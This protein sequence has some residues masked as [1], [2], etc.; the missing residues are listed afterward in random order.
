MQ[1]LP[2]CRRDQLSLAQQ[3]SPESKHKI[4]GQPFPNINCFEY[5]S[6]I[7]ASNG[8]SQRRRSGKRPERPSLNL[9]TVL[10]N[11]INAK[12][13]WDTGSTIDIIS[14]DL[15]KRVNLKPYQ[16]SSITITHVGGT[17]RSDGRTTINLN[18]NNQT[19]QVDAH[20]FP[21][22]P[23]DMIVSNQ[24]YQLFTS[25]RSGHTLVS[26]STSTYV[27]TSKTS[28]ISGTTSEDRM[29]SNHSS[30]DSMSPDNSSKD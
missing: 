24:T 20:I 30:Q 26:E 6:V 23:V 14:G 7:T 18:F 13:L 21:R 19:K 2:Q 28:P 8:L 11:G 9:F 10:V 12:A 25:H 3:L 22:S 5:F 16:N 29:S 1:I 27:K 15:A 17:A 4:R